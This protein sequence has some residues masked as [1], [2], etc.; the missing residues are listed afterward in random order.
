MSG[1]HAPLIGPTHACFAPLPF[2][3][4][5]PTMFNAPRPTQA[6]GISSSFGGSFV[7]ENPLAAS[8]FDGLDP[9]SA[10]PSPSPPPGQVPSI[11]TNAIGTL[12]TST[13]ENHTCP[14]L[15]DSASLGFNW[16]F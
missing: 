12:Y 15:T 11:F 7:D 1:I 9:W 8:T 5:S 13:S 6:Y 16:F 2:I 14:W 3:A 10:A 4:S